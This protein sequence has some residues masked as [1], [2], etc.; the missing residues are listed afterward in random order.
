MPAT[1]TQLATGE[2]RSSGPA[3]HEIPWIST[4]KGG[5]AIRSIGE[6]FA[7]SPSTGTGSVTVPIALS[8][9]RSRSGP[10]LALSYDSGSGNGPFGLGWTLGVPAITR[11]TDRGVPGYRD[12]E[13]SDVFVLSGAEDLVPVT[14]PAL[15][16]ATPRTVHGTSY[17]ITAYR[18]R[19]EG[20]FARIERWVDTDS[21]IGHWRTISRDNVTTLY[22]RSGDRAMRCD[23][24]PATEPN[25]HNLSRSSRHTAACAEGGSARPRSSHGF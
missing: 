2:P 10:G 7:V 8:P 16:P 11:R 9:G 6:T 18:P 3:S 13:E 23:K 25:D 4:P 20:L 21:G 24:P 17:E 14:D 22:G 1:G 15:L 5:G 12:A 19:V